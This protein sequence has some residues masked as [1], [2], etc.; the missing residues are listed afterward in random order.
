MPISRGRDAHLERAIVASA[1]ATIGRS[2]LTCVTDRQSARCPDCGGGPSS[3]WRASGSQALRVDGRGAGGDRTP[4]GAARAQG[5]AQAA[6]R[7][8]GAAAAGLAGALPVQR[9]RRRRSRAAAVR[10]RHRAGRPLVPLGRPAAQAR[11]GRRPRPRRSSCAA[12]STASRTSTRSLLV[13]TEATL[14]ALGDELH[15]PVDLRRFR[16]NL[17]LDLDAEGWAELAWEGARAG[18]R[19]RRPAAASCT[20]ASAA[21]SPRAHPDTQI[22]WPE[23]AAP[24]ARHP[25]AVLRDQ[26]ACDHG[27][28]RR[29]RRGGRVDSRFRF[30][31]STV[32]KGPRRRPEWRIRCFASTRPPGRWSPLRPAASSR[33]PA[34]NATSCWPWLGPRGPRSPRSWECPT[35][36]SSPP[37]PPRASTCSRST[38]SP[39]ARSCC[40]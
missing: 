3:R 7:P 23:P 29:G 10:D 32:D 2:R 1:G 24:S 11:A 15:G 31:A 28:P 21:R 34:L 18:V 12:T 20:R 19:G 25:R 38:S 9:Q 26:R 13:T 35:C 27:R 33:R 5:R 16:P 30:L 8:R 40:T 17:H 36:A 37:S 39:A 6:D 4:C 22:K 14:Q